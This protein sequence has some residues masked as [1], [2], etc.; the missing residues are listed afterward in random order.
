MK[1]TL[2]LLCLFSVCLVS[3]AQVPTNGLIGS[4]IFSGNASDGSPSANHGLVNG[5]TLCPDRFS[6]C[7]SAY[8]F[9]GIN[10]EIKMTSGGPT[11]SNA[12]SLCFW[13]KTNNTLL[14]TVFGY[15]T[16]NASGGLYQVLYNHTCPSLGFDLSNGAMSWSDPALLTN[17]WH[18]V[19]VVIDPVAGT[20]LNDIKFYYDGVLMISAACGVGAPN[21]GINIVP[22]IPVIIGRDPNGLSRYFKG[23]LDD[24]YF[25]NRA[26]SPAEI[27][28]IYKDASTNSG[29]VLAISGKT[30]V[31]AGNPETYSIIPVPGAT[32]YS[33]TFGTWQGTSNTNTILLTPNTNAATISVV[34]TTTCGTKTASIAIPQGID[35]STLAISGKTLTCPY[36]PE[37]YSVPAITGAT[38]YS[39]SFGSWQGS[40]STNTILLMPTSNQATISVAITTTCG[41]KTVTLNAKTTHCGGLQDY[42]PG[43][44]VTIYPNPVKDLLTLDNVAGTWK[45]IVIH[46]LLGQVVLEQSLEDAGTFRLYVS[47]LPSGIYLFEVSDGKNNS[48][49]KFIKE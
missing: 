32:L 4:W 10:D 11:G 27:M 25:Y 26:L 31:C 18:H 7:N 38:S 40:S 43:I 3:R 1:K 8:S 12:S 6:N 23:D 44:P 35:T 13:T 45:K 37:T 2:L 19:A 33:W 36:E 41:I 20:N 5:A 39:W 49:K 28:T 15:G 14:Q 16:S 48:V 42:V 17:T 47:P 21:P 29:P 46:D 24:F 9:D 34:A 22:S 30:L